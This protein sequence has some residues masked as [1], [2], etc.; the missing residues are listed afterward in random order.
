MSRLNIIELRPNYQAASHE[1]FFPRDS[2][3]ETRHSLPFRLGDVI[4]SSWSF[5][6]LAREITYG[7]LLCPQSEFDLPLNRLRHGLEALVAI[8][9]PI[10][11]TD[12]R[13]RR[14]SRLPNA[15]RYV[16]RSRVNFYISLHG[17]F[18]SYLAGLP[19]KARHELVR[20]RRNLIHLVGEGGLE[21]REYRRPEHVDEF[22]SIAHAISSRTYQYRQL[23][24]GL[25]DD[26]QFRSELKAQAATDR[27]RGYILFG[28]DRP[29]AFGLCVVQRDILYYNKTGYDPD[30]WRC[31]PGIVL[32][33]GLLELAF[34]EQ[35]YTIV[36]LG[37]GEAQWKRTYGIPMELREAYYFRPT[38]RN[39][40]LAAGHAAVTG[41]SDFG[42]HLLSA[43]HL[44]ERYKKLCHRMWSLKTDGPDNSAQ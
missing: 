14:V 17:T 35:R 20:K 16:P 12:S 1:P 31:S 2:W 15:I 10:S 33:Y 30:M 23:K 28:K 44:K 22:Q 6:A 27:L 37:I 43:L 42:G 32:L 8:P 38:V 18:A 29:I 39:A 26:E 34:A 3:I 9:C 25:P 24:L 21:I 40:F 19:V 36:N 13:I 41:L 7:D 5:P 4:F 11:T